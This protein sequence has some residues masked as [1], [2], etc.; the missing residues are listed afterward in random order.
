MLIPFA[1]AVFDNGTNMATST[2]YNSYTQ[3]FN[4]NYASSTSAISNN[5]FTGSFNVLGNYT[6]NKLSVGGNGE[7]LVFISGK[8]Y[9]T[10]LSGNILYVFSIENNT[11]LFAS[12]ATLPHNAAYSDTRFGCAFINGEW[13]PTHDVDIVFLAGGYFYSYHFNRTDLTLTKIQELPMES[14]TS[15]SALSCSKFN[16]NEPKALYMVD[17]IMHMFNASASSYS[18]D[19]MMNLTL[20]ANYSIINRQKL[21]VGTFDNENNINYAY[22]IISDASNR[23]LCSVR[24]NNTVKCVA[25]TGYSDLT[26][27]MFYPYTI[28]NYIATGSLQGFDINMTLWNYNLEPVCSKGDSAMSSSLSTEYITMDTYKDVGVSYPVISYV[29]NSTNGFTSYQGIRVYDYGCNILMNIT[30]ISPTTSV[31]T[32]AGGFSSSNYGT[33]FGDINGDSF[34][35]YIFSKGIISGSRNNEFSGNSSLY[36]AFSYPI[37]GIFAIVDVNNDGLVDLFSSNNSHTYMYINNY[38]PPAYCT[39]SVTMVT[40]NTGTP[41]CINSTIRYDAVTNLCEDVQLY[42]DCYG[43][44]AQIQQSTFSS[45][46][47]VNCLMNRSIDYKTKIYVYT[48]SGSLLNPLYY[49]QNLGVVI[50]KAYPECYSSGQG[51]KDINNTASAGGGIVPGAPEQSLSNIFEGLGFKTAASKCFLALII[52]IIVTIGVA[53]LGTYVI[54]IVDLITFIGLVF[55]GLIPFWVLM[56]IV[57]MMIFLVFLGFFRRSGSGGA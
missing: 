19:D 53:K 17:T 47:F 36:P 31:S 33:L 8:S 55:I 28:N 7:N 9:L 2:G 34:L 16:H 24:E 51:G 56:V 20:S 29:S 23:K 37:T 35:D 43:D 10:F 57:I 46:P 6:L 12:E 27:G 40:S 44:G 32:L 14:Y 5:V 21:E 25:I 41:T 52:L 49:E 42:V 1:N 54:A 38:S 26:G 45:T 22:S 18:V 30:Y 11:F 48:H 39:E 3:L 15:L 50:N 13:N 4:P